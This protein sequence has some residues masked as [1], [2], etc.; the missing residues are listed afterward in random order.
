[1]AGYSKLNR[2]T[3]Q[4]KALLRNQ[5]SVLLMYGKIK[6]TQT[7]AKDVC[8]LAEKMISLAVKNH[9]KVVKL[10]KQVNNEKG[11]TVTIEVTNDAP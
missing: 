5:V 1:M 10:S 7:R 4:R 9:D 6:T 11:Q 3:D 2:P 8:R